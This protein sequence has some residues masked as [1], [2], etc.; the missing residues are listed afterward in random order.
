MVL[1]IQGNNNRM[2]CRQSSSPELYNLM[3]LHSPGNQNYINK[4][5]QWLQGLAQLSV[6]SACKCA[7]LRSR[8]CPTPAQ[9]ICPEGNTSACSSPQPLCCL[10]PA[11]P[12]DSPAE[13]LAP[14]STPKPGRIQSDS[15]ISRN[16]Q[17]HPEPPRAGK[18]GH[19]L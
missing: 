11:A 2:L 13:L 14:A 1:N 12:R 10:V 4:L 3:W 17:A 5:S 6:C 18:G 8:S 15:L 19:Q 9:Q 7:A 16:S